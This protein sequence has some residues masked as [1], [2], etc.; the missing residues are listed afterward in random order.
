VRAY[1]FAKLRRI[2][3]W[4]EINIQHKK[5]LKI[6]KGKKRIMLPQRTKLMYSTLDASCFIG[7][8][9]QGRS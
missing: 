2:P 6:L 8:T 3:T 7:S 4:K 1:S 5:A 9:S